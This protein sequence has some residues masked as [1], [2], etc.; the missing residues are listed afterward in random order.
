VLPILALA[1]AAAVGP[2]NVPLTNEVPQIDGRLDEALWDHAVVANGFTQTE[3]RAGQ[4]AEKRTE[5]YI[6]YTRDLLLIGARLFDE[7]PSRVV[8]TEYRRDAPLQSEDCFEVYL[9]TFL[10]RRNAYYFATNAVGARL[11]GLVRDE[12]ATLNFEWDGVW[13]VA[14]R[15]DDRGWLVE[16]AIPFNTLRFDE[17]SGSGWGANFGRTVARTREETYWAPIDPN[18]GFDAKYRV[19]AFG[20]LVGITAADPGGR[21]KLKPYGLAGAERD[22]D[23]SDERMEATGGIDAKIGLSSAF[24]LDLTLNTDFAQVEA[25]QQQVNLTRFPLFFPEKRE[26]FLENAGLFR[27]GEA[28]L[29]FEPPATLLFFSRRIGLSEDGDEIP[30]FGGARLTGRSGRTEIGAFGIAAEE[31]VLEEETVP[32]TFFG[33]ARVKRDVLARSSVGAMVLSKSPSTESGGSGRNDVVSAD[34]NLAYTEHTELSGLVAKSFTTSLEGDDHAG[35]LHANWVTDEASVYGDYVDVGENFNSEMGFVPRTGIRKY[36]LNAFWSPR[37]RKLGIRQIFLSND[38]VYIEDRDGDLETQTNALGPFLVF[39][40]G[41]FLSGAWL[42]QAEGLKEP[43]E[44]RDG[45][46]IP[47]GQYRFNRFDAAYVGD[48]SRRVAVNAFFSD[49]GFYDGTLR[50]Y[51]LGVDTKPHPR[52]RASAAYFRNDVDLPVEG[53]DFVTNLL[54]LRGIVAFSPDAYVRALVQFNDD[55]EEALANVL[56]RYSYR[57]GSDLFVVY[58]EERD[59]EGAGTSPR[60][61]ELVVKVTFYA[62]PF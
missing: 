24:N 28:N 6:A 47:P 61:R 52:I 32:Q 57:P 41:S 44:I 14:S 34:F 58:N 50:S 56:F 60:N 62:V 35:T 23:E 2:L 33:A 19:S 53:G 31:A 43:F 1:S 26:F 7:E 42:Y 20:E 40:N 39:D 29:P 8:A 48:Q 15:I 10:D 3:P 51:G 37:P 12:G 54:I 22:F 55:S 16:M 5:V 4:P 25:D 30:I 21:F 49:G 9:D 13:E 46:D 45:V 17:G 18:W 27:V 59:T 36:R 38:H 11:D